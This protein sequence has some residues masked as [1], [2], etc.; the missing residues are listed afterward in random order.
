VLQKVKD[1]QPIEWETID[2]NNPETWGNIEKEL[3]D[4]KFNPSEIARIIN[5]ALEA[6]SLS[7]HMIDAAVQDFLALKSLQEVVESFPVEEHGS[8]QSG[9]PASVSDVDHPA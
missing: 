3:R 1:T 5:G 4:A 9:E 6:N 2:L 8:T 7:E